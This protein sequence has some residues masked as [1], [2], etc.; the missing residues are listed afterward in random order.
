MGS[1]DLTQVLQVL[2]LAKLSLQPSSKCFSQ[3][4]QECSLLR[5]FTMQVSVYS[6]YL[7]QLTRLS[8]PLARGL[9]ERAKAEVTHSL[10][11]IFVLLTRL[12]ARAVWDW[13]QLE[14]LSAALLTNRS[15]DR[16][17]IPPS[18]FHCREIH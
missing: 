9:L 4:L 6:H 15:S 11:L 3:N 18:E 17:N 1:E 13:S 12:P 2:L 5:W 8:T 10:A 14:E 7:F 16:A